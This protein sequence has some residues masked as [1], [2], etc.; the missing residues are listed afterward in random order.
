VMEGGTF[1][2]LFRMAVRSMA[3]RKPD[4]PEPHET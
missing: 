2:A 3:F 1:Q 4:R